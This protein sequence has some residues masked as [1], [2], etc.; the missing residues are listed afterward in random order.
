M[1]AA[2]VRQL[3]GRGANVLAVDRDEK[4]LQRL[5]EECDKG[6]AELD[7]AAADV[8][9]T[10][11]VE[12]FVDRAVG[13]WGGLDGIFN[14][15]G[16]GTGEFKPLAEVSNETYDEVMRV[17]ARSV[18]LGMKYTLPHLVARGGGAIVNTG[19]HLAWHAAPTFSAYCASKHAVI[20][21]T[22]AVALEY[23]QYNIRANVVCPSAMDTAMGQEAA[24]GIAPEDP[25]LGWKILIDQ[26]AN[27]RVGH[28]EESAAV[29][30][31]LLLDAPQ[32]VSG[33]L[34]PV[35]GAQSAK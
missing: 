32:H 29:G 7:T 20:G 4:G 17:N 26:S 15:A 33:I 3:L 28:A 24:E 30:V 13:R 25:Q 18:W 34:V 35:D 1:G 10:R 11:D 22:K 31:W 12:A 14:I 5:A 6:E 9:S 2:A 27:G 23:G 16:V 21:M 8:G 19:S